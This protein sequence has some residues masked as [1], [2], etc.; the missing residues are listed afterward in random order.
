MARGLAFLVALLA[1]AVNLRPSLTGVGPLLQTIQLD[2]GLSPT[3]AGILTS[4]PLL[5]FGVFAPV[6]RL[7]RSLG[8]E[9]M[10][11]AGLIA[12][13][14]GT[15]LRSE[16]STL[17]LFAGTVVLASGIAVLNVLLPTI[18]KQHYPER[19]AASLRRMP[20]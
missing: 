12:L 13:I 9:R 3:Q 5:M 6:A 11:L 1:I 15:L 2:L 14:A 17:A 8:T 10:A 7:A 19:V 20:P 16:G 18:V 4:L